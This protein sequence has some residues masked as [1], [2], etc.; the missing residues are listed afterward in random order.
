[1]FVI[2]ATRYNHKRNTTER[3]LA[4]ANSDQ[5]KNGIFEKLE[6]AIAQIEGAVRF[7]VETL[8]AQ[9]WYWN[10]YT[11]PEKAKGHPTIEQETYTFT[12]RPL[13]EAVVVENLGSTQKVA[14]WLNST[15]QVADEDD[16]KS[17]YDDPGH[18]YC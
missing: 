8:G 6:D 7:D 5:C 9:K 14:D 13:G 2:V 18:D 15:Q 12:I 10:S 1:M 4:G 11:V 3:W 16:I 17:T